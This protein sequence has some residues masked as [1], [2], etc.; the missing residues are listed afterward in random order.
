[1]GL[2]EFKDEAYYDFALAKQLQVQGYPAVLIQ[3]GESTFYLIA[4]GYTD[5]DTLE[6]RIK[7]AWAISASA[8]ATAAMARRITSPC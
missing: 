4:K 5:I 6:A 3:R 8:S 7:K 2:E 1:M